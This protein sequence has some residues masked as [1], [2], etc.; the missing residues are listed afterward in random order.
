M[1]FASVPP[2]E[3]QLCHLPIA[4]TKQTS[5]LYIITLANPW[6]KDHQVIYTWKVMRCIGSLDEYS[7]V[8]SLSLPS[9]T[10][11][12][13]PDVSLHVNPYISGT[14]YKCAKSAFKYI[15]KKIQFKCT[16]SNHCTYTGALIACKT[17]ASVHKNKGLATKQQQQIRSINSAKEFFMGKVSYNNI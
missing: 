5:I 10:T 16:L 6:Y 13:R 15:N 4:I 2:H 9:H 17:H 14:S 1:S 8:F 12:G 7:F 3:C 11:H